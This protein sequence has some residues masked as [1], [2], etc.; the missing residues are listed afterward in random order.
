LATVLKGMKAEGHKVCCVGHAGYTEHPAFFLEFI[1]IEGMR[2][3][4]FCR[5]QR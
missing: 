3:K 4:R 2:E 5:R 1:V